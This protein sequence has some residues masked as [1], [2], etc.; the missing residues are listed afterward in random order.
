MPEG[1]RGDIAKGAGREANESIAAKPPCLRQPS[2]AR[3]TLLGE[4][5][6]VARERQLGPRRGASGTLIQRAFSRLLGGGLLGFFFSPMANLACL[7][8]AG[9]SKVMM[10][11]VYR[12]LVVVLCGMM[13]GSRKRRTSSRLT[14]LVWSWWESD[15]E[16]SVRSRQLLM[17]V[18]R[19]D[20]NKIWGRT[21]DVG[22]GVSFLLY[23]MNS[24]LGD[25]SLPCGGTILYAV[26]QS[27]RRRGLGLVHAPK[28]PGG[29]V[30]GG[31]GKRRVRTQVAMYPR[32]GARETKVPTQP[33]LPQF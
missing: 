10:L 24:L 29:E 11:Y 16:E 5:Q 30:L 7:V 17:V 25:G 3:E 9:G 28:G 22:G 26:R 19:F 18:T 20:D 12:S 33:R 31:H 32:R 6:K 4:S 8:F 13:V 14:S 27:S 21:G 1:G 15:E 23:M 2:S